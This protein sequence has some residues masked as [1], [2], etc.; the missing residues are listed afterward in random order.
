MKVIMI[1]GAAD[2]IVCPI[3]EFSHEIF[4]QG[5]HVRFF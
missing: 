2:F 1:Y 3:Y 4:D 5:Q